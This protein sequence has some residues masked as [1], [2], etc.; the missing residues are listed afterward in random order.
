MKRFL[1]VLV[2]L[3]LLT[4]CGSVERYNQQIAKQHS[5]IELHEDV[6]KAYSQYQK[7]HPRLYQYTPKEDLDYKID[8]LKRAITQP[9]GSQAFYE[10]LAQVLTHIRQGH[11]SVV[12][13]HKRFTKKERKALL[14]KKL[15]F[16]DLRFEYL[17]DK[18]WVSRTIGKDSS[19]VGAEVV[20]LDDEKATD[21]INK[22]NSWY[23]SDGYNTTLFD[24]FAGKRFKGFYYRDK[25]Y[26][27]SLEVTFKVRDSLF[28]KM[29]KRIDRKKKAADSSIVKKDS[30][31][32]NSLTKA[33]RKAR[34][35]KFKKKRK[36][37]KKHG[38]VATSK[39]YNRN[40]NR[41]GKDS[42]VAYLKIR[43]FTH[44]KFKEFY[45]ESFAAID[46]LGIENLVIDLRDN[47]GGRIAEIAYLYSFLT[48]KPHQFIT[49]SEV[50]SRIPFL[51]MLMSNTNPF[52]LKAVV[53]L[54]SPIL[55]TQNLI[56]VK[57]REGKLYYKFKYAKEKDP[58][59][60]NF[61]G[62]IYV[63]I[64]GNSF[65]ASSI[66]S[67]QLHANKRATFV[68]EETGGAYNGT[69][70]GIFK[71]YELPNSKVKLRIG[72]MQVET[73]YKVEPDGYG[74]PAD[75]KIT[76]THQDRLNN[77]DPELEWVL[78]DIKNR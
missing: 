78:N 70:A 75:V 43:G 77:I 38:Y 11:V 48:D 6:D 10:K 18:L 24:K 19:L 20:S 52:A 36:Y 53:G 40:F 54:L 4:S 67:T 74:V 13:P 15:E 69:V 64:N 47:G 39:L 49:E 58:N 63:L 56:K 29:F 16:N 45:E 9:M 73:P 42:S 1:I 28:I 23:A 55:I 12:P 26:L 22:Y 72:M 21:L 7:H 33:K 41:I 37:N 8:S 2:M 5:V 60:L 46:S 51:K 17:D 32:R 65:S 50:N 59:L 62:H 66:L 34:K 14:K 31:P 68:G 76:P 71:Y 30:L 35:L 27:D 61:K 44:G 25:G 57:K 3:L